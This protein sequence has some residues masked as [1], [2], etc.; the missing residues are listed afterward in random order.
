M[1]DFEH[2]LTKKISEKEVISTPFPH[3]IIENFLPKDILNKYLASFPQKNIKKNGVKT[4]KN[5]K[6]IMHKENSSEKFYMDNKLFV[7]IKSYHF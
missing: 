4:S 2:Y 5:R 3:F 7:I 6:N 1:N